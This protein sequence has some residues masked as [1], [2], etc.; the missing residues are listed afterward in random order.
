[1]TEKDFRELVRSYQKKGLR[2]IPAVYTALEKAIAEDESKPHAKFACG[3]GCS[4]CCYQAVTCTEAE[5]L[6]IARHID[7]LPK[8]ER[9][10]LMNLA[11]ERSK[12]V[13]KHLE[14][15]SIAGTIATSVE[16]VKFINSFT[17]YKPCPFLQ[18]DGRC[19]IYPV[20]PIDCRT[21]H[22]TSICQ[23]LHWP[24]A[25]RYVPECE[26]WAN[27]MILEH[28]RPMY[29]QLVHTWFLQWRMWIKDQKTR[30]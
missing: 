25:K 11:H 6:E 18:A 10:R 9:S 26:S 23:S 3:A 4:Q 28:A 19:G 27:S 20:R 17:D 7:S 24:D 13:Q 12:E 1:M 8:K 2:F 16:E 30:R 5:F 22:S 21:F 29:V 15:T 14:E